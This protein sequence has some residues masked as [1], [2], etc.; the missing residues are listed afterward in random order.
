[1]P[2]YWIRQRETVISRVFAYYRL[3]YTRK[4]ETPHSVQGPRL[5]YSG[6]AR[7]QVLPPSAGKEEQQYKSSE[8]YLRTPANDQ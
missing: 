6:E 1:M 3:Y 4:K 5:G 2:G 8:D 7:V